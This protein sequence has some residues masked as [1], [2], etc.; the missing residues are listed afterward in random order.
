MALGRP[1]H[2]FSARKG[3]IPRSIFS[4]DA[5]GATLI[6][7]LSLSLPFLPKNAGHLG[8]RF[9]AKIHNPN[10][11]VH[12]F[13]TIGGNPADHTGV[14]S[15]EA[16]MTLEGLNTSPRLDV[17]ISTLFAGGRTVEYLKLWAYATSGGTG[18]LPNVDIQTMMFSGDPAPTREPLIIVPSTAPAQAGVDIDCVADVTP[19][20]LLASGIRNLANA[21]LRRLTTPRG[22]LFY[23]ADYGLD[24]RDYLNAGL[25]DG[26]IGALAGAVGLELE[27]DERV[28]AAEVSLSYAAG[29]LRIRCR[30]ST[31]DLGDMSFLLQVGQVSSSVLDLSVVA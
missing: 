2:V 8:V 17:D 11:G 4:T 19:Q 22:G 29:S 9:V 30:V 13:V 7:N 20:F 24:L 5:P 15:P 31:V 12:V 23:D 3:L 28:A 26:E 14:A 1:L 10:L 6:E 25:T 21:L 18:G 16:V 27:K